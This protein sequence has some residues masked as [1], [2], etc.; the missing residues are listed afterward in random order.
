MVLLLGLCI[1]AGS[2]MRWQSEIDLNA[3][4]QFKR[5]V[6]RV[7]AD[8][9]LRFRQPV[10]FKRAPTVMPSDSNVQPFWRPEIFQEWRQKLF[11]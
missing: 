8:V 9:A 10:S 3:E 1:A 7:V 11:N 4:V 5:S 6:E 2:A